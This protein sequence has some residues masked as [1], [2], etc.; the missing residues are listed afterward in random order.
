MQ[1]STKPIRR[2]RGSLSRTEILSASMDIILE[3][4]V[5]ALSMRR[6]AKKIGCSVASPYTHFQ[7][8][9]EI[10]RHL[11][12]IGEKQLTHDLREAQK[13]R[14]DVYQSL[15]AIAHAYWNFASDNRELHKLMFNA[16]GGKLYRQTFPSLPTSYRVF[17][18]TIRQGISSGEILYSRKDYPA[19]AR[20]MW[21]WMYG[22]IVLEMNE[23][24]RKRKDS[25]PI[26]EGIQLFTILLKRGGE[27]NLKL[28]N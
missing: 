9:E 13:N 2:S 24:L 10:I 26:Q 11:I 27:L 28:D 22:L 19:I 15:D 25:D 8:Q 3:E 14:G 12:L 21:S 23:L 16:V 6:I 7:N 18:E 4:G 20:T 1:G 17:L 5:E